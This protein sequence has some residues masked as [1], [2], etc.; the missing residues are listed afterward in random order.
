M[1]WPR[2]PHKNGDGEPAAFQAWPASGPSSRW[3][4][5][6]D[7]WDVPP[8][9]VAKAAGADAEAQALDDGSVLVGGAAKKPTARRKG[10]GGERWKS[11]S[12]PTPAG[13]PRCG[14]N[15]CRTLPTTTVVSAADG[16]ARP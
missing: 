11:R 7:G 15:C 8:I 6:P 14:W 16:T 12:S 13:S 9:A 2:P 1:T 5:I 3:P 4:S 10:A